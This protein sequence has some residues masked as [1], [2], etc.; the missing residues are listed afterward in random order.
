MHFCFCNV[1]ATPVKLVSAASSL[2]LV[3]LAINQLTYRLW[4]PSSKIF[5]GFLRAR[6]GKP[7]SSKCLMSTPSSSCS[8][9]KHLRKHSKNIQ[10]SQLCQLCL[11]VLLHIN[12]LEITFFFSTWLPGPGGCVDDFEGT[13]GHGGTQHAGAAHAT[14]RDFGEAGR[15]M[16]VQLIR[17][18]NPYL[19]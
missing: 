16:L 12:H 1:G 17:N 5:V 14:R 15:F 6:W 8:Q 19:T 18:R 11:P 7:N 13:S 2:N 9:R 10:K 3:S 4:A